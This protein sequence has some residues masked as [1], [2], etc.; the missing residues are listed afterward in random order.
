MH[1]HKDIVIKNKWL[2]II[3]K[4]VLVIHLELSSN[5]EVSIWKYAFTISPMSMIFLKKEYEKLIFKILS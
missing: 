4:Y 1:I 2:S 3:S 5:L